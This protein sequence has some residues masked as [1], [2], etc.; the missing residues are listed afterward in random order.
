MHILVYFVYIC[1]SMHICAS[2]NVSL[3]R[4]ICNGAIMY[5]LAPGNLEE[6]FEVVI[7]TISSAS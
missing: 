3:G 6:Q 4:C 7:L 5:I 2:I 1:I